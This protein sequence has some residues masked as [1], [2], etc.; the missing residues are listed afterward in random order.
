MMEC[1]K[2][3]EKID[4]L[5]DG[6]LL[7]GEVGAVLEHMDTCRDCRGYRDDIEKMGKGIRSYIGEEV[8]AIP[9]NLILHRV[10]ASI[11]ELEEEKRRGWFIRY[12]NILIPSL[13]GVVALVLILFYPSSKAP[14][15]AP[16][17]AERNDRTPGEFTKGPGKLRF[18]ATV[19]SLEAEGADVVLVDRGTDDPKVIWI[20]EGD[21]R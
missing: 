4:L 12:R 20:I 5:V 8:E 9:E 1:G 10:E 13:V 11:A 15:K 3:R 17:V 21:N 16:Q 19:E 2:I 6:Y 7:S 14:Y 18:A